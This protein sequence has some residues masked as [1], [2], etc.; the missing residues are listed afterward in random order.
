M[1]LTLNAGEQIREIRFGYPAGWVFYEDGA[2]HSVRVRRC[3]RDDKRDEVYFV[4]NR[5]INAE[6]RLRLKGD[7][8]NLNLFEEL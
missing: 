4:H 8:E 7:D 2:K 3:E 1:Q 6:Q 5:S